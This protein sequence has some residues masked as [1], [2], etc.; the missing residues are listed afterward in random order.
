MA[1]NMTL[2]VVSTAD[3]VEE[4]GRM[5][6]NF[7]VAREFVDEALRRIRGDEEDTVYY[8][9]GGPHFQRIYELAVKLENT[10]AT[11]N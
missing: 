5:K 2:G 6:G 4:I 1:T 7:P 11:R 3:L 9:G 8:F 10:A